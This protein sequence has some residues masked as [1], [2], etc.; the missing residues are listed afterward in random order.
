LA[1]AYSEAAMINQKLQLE[2]QS[3]RFDKVT[4]RLK[5]MMEIMTNSECY[6]KEIVDLAVEH[7]KQIMQIPKED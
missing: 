5:L 7:M 1:K 6:P 4:E 3:T 2:L